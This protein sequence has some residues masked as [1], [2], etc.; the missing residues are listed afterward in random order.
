M[1]D[2]NVILVVLVKVLTD[3]VATQQ[4]TGGKNIV[5]VVLVNVLTDWVSTDQDTGGKYVWFLLK[6][7]PTG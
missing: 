6:Y 7:L 1:H 2:K 5:I 3:W 4:D